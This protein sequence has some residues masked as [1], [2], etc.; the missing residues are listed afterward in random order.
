[1]LQHGRSQKKENDQKSAR[2]L[3]LGSSTGTLTNN[4]NHLDYA[5]QGSEYN[6]K[7]KA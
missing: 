5:D 7:R 3:Y 2:G 4:E 1:M 6:R